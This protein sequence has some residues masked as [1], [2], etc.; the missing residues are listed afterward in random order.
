MYDVGTSVLY[1]RT[2][3]CRVEG[4]GTPPFRR[5]DGQ[6]YYILRSVFSASG[7]RIYIPV[8]TAVSMRPLVDSGEAAACLDRL[9]RLEPGIFAARRPA[10]L[11]AHYQEVLAA[12][13]L[14]GCL[15]LMKEVYRKQQT[16]KKLGQ[17]DARYLKIAQRLAC[18]ELA[19]VLELEPETVKKRLYRAMER[20]PQA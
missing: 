10:D 5:E 18:E 14:E 12:C 3:V 16:G 20:A 7:E 9:S 11:V 1:G 13:D 4:I 2:G 6:S 15:L 19:A 8:D 17:V